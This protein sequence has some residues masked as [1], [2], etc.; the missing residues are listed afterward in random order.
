MLYNKIKYA[1][2]KDRDQAARIK[3]LQFNAQIEI[4]D[5][6]DPDEEELR[7]FFRTCALTDKQQKDKLRECLTATVK[8]RDKMLTEHQAA[9]IDMFPFFYVDHSLVIR[10]FRLKYLKY[11]INFC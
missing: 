8:L 1:A 11:F 9:I 5:L 2:Q 10:V 4:A 3:G 6:P 7:L